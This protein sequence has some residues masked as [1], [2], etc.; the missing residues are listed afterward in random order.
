MAATT[1]EIPSFNFAAYFYPQIL[2]SLILFKRQ[3]IPELTDENDFETSIQLLRAFA[4]VGHLN[5]VVADM[6]ANESTLTTAK[7][8]ETVRN[9]LRL[10]DFELRP[11]A[12]AAVPI[13][14]ALSRVYNVS[15]QVVPEL[16]QFSTRRTESSSEIIYFEA[17]EALD[18]DR[19]DQFT[20]VY[21]TDDGE[22]FNDFTTEANAGTTFSP[23]T[24]PTVGSAIYFGHAQV[25]HNRL[26]ITVVTTPGEITIGVWEFYDGDYYDVEPDSV[27]NA[28]GGVLRFNVND[29]LGDQ[30]R[31]GALVRV[32]INETATGEIVESQWDGSNNY[33][34][35]SLL[36]QA[37]PS[38]DADDYTVGVQWQELDDVND[39][40][41]LLSEID[42]NLVEFD[43]PQNE[44][45]AWA[46]TEIN[47]TTAY[48][49]R[50][51]IIQTSGSTPIQLS[52]IRMDQGNQYVSVEA[53]QGR[54]IIGE[55]LGSSNGDENQQFETTN[56]AFILNSNTLR[57]DS[58]EWTEV[59][60]F[61]SSLPQDKHYRVV[62]GDQNRAT[63]VFGDGVNGRIPDVGQGNI[64]LDYRFGA[65]E[66]GNVGARTVTVDKTGLSFINGIFN[67]R[68][69]TGWA[70]AQSDS[71][72]GLEKAKIEG[73]ASLRTREVA[74]STTDVETLATN[75]TADDGSSP[76]SRATAIEEGYG[77]KT[78]ELVVVARGG[79]Q[80]TAEQ[81]AALDTYF[82]GDTTATPELPKR[83]VANQQ[84]VSVN[85]D[86]KPIDVVATVTAPSTVTA[87]QVR[88]QLASILQPEALKS[89]GVTWVWRFGGEVP[90]SRIMHEIFQTSSL[91]KKVVL[92]TPASDTQL[93]RRQLPSN[94]S[95]TIVMV[96][97]SSS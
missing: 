53:T 30:N 88:N 48:W 9:M 56:D 14:L 61:L 1:I 70:E 66:D 94:G 43:L 86:P 57:V 26:D 51:R 49:I 4:L 19:T 95:F 17:L 75:Y 10:I 83:I 68:Q 93:Q 38:L 59:D 46:P 78:V 25:Q 32:Q 24:V 64:E 81:L 92:T 31:S 29:L 84:V 3:N 18:V 21:A 40:T 65:A 77:P 27:I 15:K 96:V 60:N 12:P 28:G 22:T 20:A 47:S 69:A 41:L 62:L 54:S 39:E 80:A 11:A 52:Q 82:N 7:L 23:W 36:G 74:I 72:A 34:E 35:T 85:Y 71:E 73:P 8:P 2:E 63:V 87:E 58:E 5:N 44:L 50:F 42:E 91:I 16:A 55:I 97:E 76:F 37:S 90:L 13:V 45:R 6:I 33:V 79:G 67:P 89:D